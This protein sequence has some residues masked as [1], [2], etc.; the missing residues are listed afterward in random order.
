M[1]FV[2]F[3]IR[4]LYLF[5][6]DPFSVP[7][8]ATMEALRGSGGGPSS[9]H[10]SPPA[11]HLAK[12]ST[13]QPPLQGK[14]IK[15]KATKRPQ[16][17]GAGCAVS[18]HRSPY[19]QSAN[20][21]GQLIKYNHASDTRNNTN[22][23]VKQL[24][25]HKTTGE[26]LVSKSV[27]AQ[28]CQVLKFEI[29]LS[30]LVQM[31]T[32]NKIFKEVRNHGLLYV[33]LYELLLGPYQSIRGGGALK[34]LLL[35]HETSLRAE[36]QRILPGDSNDPRVAGKGDPD[37]L[38]FPRYIRLNAWTLATRE[39]RLA[40]VLELRQQLGEHCGDPSS[41]SVFI[42]PHIPDLLV[43]PPNS[44][45]K[46]MSNDTIRQRINGIITGSKEAEVAP[47]DL[48]LQDKSSCFPAFCLAHGFDDDADLNSGC[49]SFDYLDACAAPGN[50]TSHLAAVL[51]QQRR[52][53][54]ARSG[55]KSKLSKR[56]PVAHCSLYALDRSRPRYELLER[57]LSQ[58][59]PS[60]EEIKVVPQNLDFLATHGS[61]YP[62]VRAILL[63][64]SCSGSGIFSSIDR[65]NESEIHDGA[66]GNGDD[67]AVPADEAK[68]SVVGAAAPKAIDRI[69]QLSSFQVK[70]LQ[71]AMGEFPNVTRIV[72]ST[73]SV[74]ATENE[75]VIRRALNRGEVNEEPNTVTKNKST[76]HEWRIVSSQCLGPLSWPRRGVPT[77]GLTR[78]ETDCM[79]RA[80]RGD[81]TNGFFVCC[82]QKLLKQQP[83]ESVA[84]A[85]APGTVMD[86][87]DLPVYSGEY[88]T[89]Q[90]KAN[91]KGSSIPDLA[92]SKPKEKAK[93]DER[94]D[95]PS[96]PKKI[97]KKLAWK[98]RQRDQKHMRE[99][100]KGK[101]KAKSSHSESP[102]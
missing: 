72:Y 20:I 48:I 26:L 13:A 16:P 98:T 8:R 97:L 87:Y 77:E 9:T 50:K 55:N 46:L 47:L 80:D 34:R 89:V 84:T 27:Y 60:K 40:V 5:Y 4:A 17:T 64:P 39:Q 75:E 3:F 79:I 83:R 101:A 73:C 93:R 36:L 63:D 61:D 33:L 7:R 43:L 10:T 85:I 18:Y 90:P 76:N 56:T 62:N 22:A 31:V 82:L 6:I 19:E 95:K 100:S 69:E 32:K 78:E 15:N 38:L 11:T 44:T 29:V 14:M 54:A 92:K 81:E 59:L 70:A 57:R 37:P 66:A 96:L 86:Q 65:Q 24:V 1:T 49:T 74:H 102:V 23:S 12:A 71:H 88:S 51:L 28:V 67:P 91:A 58:M 52:I 45:G 94:R 30:K 68:L 2:P 35:K 41:T 53:L 25:Y 21:L 99:R 42:D